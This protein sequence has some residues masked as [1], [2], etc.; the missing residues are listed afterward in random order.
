MFTG[1]VRESKLKWYSVNWIA[2]PLLVSEFVSPTAFLKQFDL[3]LIIIPRLSLVVTFGQR[4]NKCNYS[5]FCY[6]TRFRVQTSYDVRLP[7]VTHF[8]VTLGRLHLS[9]MTE[10]YFSRFSLAKVSSFPD[11]VPSFS[12]DFKGWQSNSYFESESF[13]S[14]FLRSLTDDLSVLRYVDSFL[15]R[16]RD[17]L[18][19]RVMLYGKQRIDPTCPFS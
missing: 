4:N 5:T 11:C 1:R 7:V 17:N 14:F 18:Y 15:R 3:Y 2:V 19:T 13:C 12:N 16:N 8:F 6:V 9:L 10:T